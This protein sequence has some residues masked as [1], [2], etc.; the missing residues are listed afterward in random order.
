MRRDDRKFFVSCVLWSSNDE[1][2]D[3]IRFL[4]HVT[5]IQY[6]QYGTNVASCFK[7]FQHY[8]STIIRMSCIILIYTITTKIPFFDCSII[9]CFDSAIRNKYGILVIPW[10]IPFYNIAICV[11]KKP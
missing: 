6:Y 11:P 10:H 1:I 9:P 2:Y 8:H 7:L 4:V 3:D 5:V